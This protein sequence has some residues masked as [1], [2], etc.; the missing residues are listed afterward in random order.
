MHVLEQTMS[1]SL[2]STSEAIRHELA[3]ATY[4]F[5][6]QYNDRPLSAETYLAESLDAYKHSFR[7][8]TELFGREQVRELLKHELDQQVLNLLAQKYWNKPFDDLS[9][10]SQRLI[11]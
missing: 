7:G 8:F 3:E 2:R 4:E 10:L 9:P 5:K 11:N 1:S 6:V